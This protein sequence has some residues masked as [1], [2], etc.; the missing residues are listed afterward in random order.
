MK[1]KNLAL[2]PLF[3]VVLAGCAPQTTGVSY[4]GQ[5]PCEWAKQ[6]LINEMQ[7]NPCA[8]IFG[9]S[10]RCVEGRI[11]RISAEQAN[12]RA[13]CTEYEQKESGAWACAEG[14]SCK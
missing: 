12:V 11:A 5:D 4:A 13:L 6:N 14:H 3:A 7:H 10:A 1:K 8:G 2:I 9:L